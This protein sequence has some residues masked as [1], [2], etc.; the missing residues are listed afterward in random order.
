[1]SFAATSAQFI[2]KIYGMNHFG[3]RN[4][5]H[6]F[7]VRMLV[8][9][10]VGQCFVDKKLML[11]GFL[12]ADFHLDIFNPKTSISVEEPLTW[13]GNPRDCIGRFLSRGDSTF[14]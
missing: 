14:L 2:V 11:G 8:S 13:F 3:N 9:S 5:F 12:L 4:S 1:M 6:C 10:P 7:S